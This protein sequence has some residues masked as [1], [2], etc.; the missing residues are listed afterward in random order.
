VGPR[1]RPWR[2][3]FPAAVLSLL[4]SCSGL[5]GAGFAGITAKLL[6]MEGN[7]FNSRRFYAEAIAAFTRALEYEEVRAYAE[8]GLGAV[9]LAMDEGAAALGR[10]DAAGEA[11]A[12]LPREQ[13][14]E[15]SYRIRYN[16]GIIRFQRGEYLAAAGEFRRALEADPG[17]IEAK[18]N[19]ELS[20]LSASPPGNAAAAPGEAAGTG[21]RAEALFDYIR[22]KEQNQWKSREWTEDGAA[23]GP[24][25]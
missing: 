15:L 17:R 14:R 11:L 7:F 21:G 25:Y 20:L 9:Y 8:Y 12:G 4:C 24:D 3:L 5:S 1:N 22:R 10:F 23:A 16:A 18:R 6:I 2:L 19:L 13:H